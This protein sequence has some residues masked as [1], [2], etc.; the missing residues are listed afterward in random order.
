MGLC[1]LQ[2][3]LNTEMMSVYVTVVKSAEDDSESA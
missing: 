1:W 3:R 2:N